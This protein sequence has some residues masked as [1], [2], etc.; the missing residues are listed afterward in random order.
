MDSSR[1]VRTFDL[2][3]KIDTMWPGLINDPTFQSIIFRVNIYDWGQITLTFPGKPKNKKIKPFCYT[4]DM[5][6]WCQD[7]QNEAMRIGLEFA[8]LTGTAVLIFDDGQKPNRYQNL[9]IKYRYKFANQIHEHT[10]YLENKHD[11]TP[12]WLVHKYQQHLITKTLKQNEMLLEK[13]KNL[14]AK[15]KKI[16]IE[17]V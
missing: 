14:L 7:G 9:T 13:I 5:I 10:E 3:I 11:N 15:L 12:Q 8:L 17:S 6:N 2:P 16:R 1:I 4:G